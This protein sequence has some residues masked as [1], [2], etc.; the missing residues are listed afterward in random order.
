MI[1]FSKVPFTNEEATGT[2]NEAAIG[3]I[4]GAR[5]LPSCFLFGV[6]LFR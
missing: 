1:P 4:K 2:I 6:L 5:N 3:A